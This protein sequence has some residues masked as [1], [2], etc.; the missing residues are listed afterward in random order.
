MNAFRNA[1]RIIGNK[2]GFLWT[3]IAY[4][5]LVFF[6]LISI[7]LAVLVPYVNKLVDL[8]GFN[9]IRRISEIGQTII[10]GESFSQVIDHI[11][12]LGTDIGGIFAGIK[13]LPTLL[14]LLLLT[15]VWRFILGLADIAFYHC[16]DM[17]L[18]S[19][20]R[21]SFR[22]SFIR[23][24]GKSA[25][26]QLCKMIFSFPADAAIFGL[27]YLVS[28]IFAAPLLLFFSPFIILFLF[29]LLY[30]LRFALFSGW[31]PEILHSENKKIFP[32]F[33]R[34]LKLL[35]HNFGRVYGSMLLFMLIAIAL[36]LFFGIFT[37]GVGLLVTIPFT[38]FIMLVLNSTLYYQ[39]NNLRYYVDKDTIIN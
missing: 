39:N 2:F 9:L 4:Y 16:V 17:H 30:S 24:I 10:D 27:L 25:K 37:L 15:A 35:G 14:V 33:C 29:V 32:A 7:C 5:A 26:Y 1:F 21:Q 6:L 19:S 28:L 20:A 34:S 23:N 12:A 3:H 18:S 38:F 31:I 11:K 8:E 13:S 36:N 22:A